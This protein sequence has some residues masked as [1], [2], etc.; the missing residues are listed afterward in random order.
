MK[1]NRWIV[2]IALAAACTSFAQENELPPP[3]AEPPP[4]RFDRDGARE[5]FRR[6]TKEIK[7]RID[8]A[9]IA[10]NSEFKALFE[11]EDKAKEDKQRM[12]Q[13]KREFIK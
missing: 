6:Q 11:K 10:G 2:A 7:K 1:S 4:P 5:E 8:E 12:R 13:L 9:L 3:D